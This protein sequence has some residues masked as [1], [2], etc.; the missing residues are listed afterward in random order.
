MNMSTMA[1]ADMIDLTIAIQH[2]HGIK[3][4]ILFNSNGLLNP[5]VKGYAAIFC[6]INRN[7]ISKRSS[8]R[9]KK[10]QYIE[11]ITVFLPCKVYE[12]GAYLDIFI[13][14]SAWMAL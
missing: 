3:F 4:V 8:F 14:V 6:E 9:R 12:T 7:L 1:N 5:N 10:V 2:S 13:V 11:E